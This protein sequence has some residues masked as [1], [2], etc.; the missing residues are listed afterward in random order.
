MVDVLL[1]H[2]NHL[3]SDRKQVEKMQPYPPLQ[4]LLA[5]SVLREHGISV[6]LFDPTLFDPTLFDSTFNN[7]EG[8]FAAALDTHQPR[9]AVVCED[10]F[11]FLSKMCL[12]RNRELAFSMAAAAGARDIPI[13]A[14]GSDASDH[15]AEYLA[16][17]FDSVLIGEVEATLVELAQGRPRASFVVL[18]I[19]M[20]GPFKGPTRR[21][22]RARLGC[23]SAARLGSGRHGSN[24]GGPGRKRTA[25]FR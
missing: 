4:T 12:G 23:A 24:T 3:Y 6:A 25:I 1:T 21:E 10:D 2:S 7:P 17:G 18:P 16:A 14:H 8:G 13:A 22:P 20:A 19:A 15:V 9:L 5:A 11:N